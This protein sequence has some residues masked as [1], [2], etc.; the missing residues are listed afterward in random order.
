MTPIIDLIRHQAAVTPE[1]IAVVYNHVSYTYRDV[2][3]LA[4][5]VAQKIVG[6]GLAQGDVVGI[7]IPRNQWMAIAPLGVL[8]AGCAYMPLDPA[9]PAE[10]LNFMMSDSRAKLLIADRE[11][12]AGSG[13]MVD[14]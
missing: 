11:V 13:L 5:G 14:G 8:A 10:R 2:M 1:N 7:L 3:A 9:Y 4:S 6:N 12:L